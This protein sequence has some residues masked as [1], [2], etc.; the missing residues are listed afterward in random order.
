MHW[1]V[2]IGGA[3]G[4]LGKKSIK[5][6]LRSDQNGEVVW[7]TEEYESLEK[8]KQ[9]VLKLKEELE[10]ALQQGEMDWE[11]SG[12]TGMNQ[13]AVINSS[14]EEVWEQMQEF[15]DVLDMSNFFNQ[16]DEELRKK[17]AD[18]ILTQVSMFKGMAPYFAQNYDSVANKMV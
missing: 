10:S 9:E 13:G 2:S 5:L 17:T 16:L 6:G 12:K 7:V 8:W 18:Y 15:E 3:Q 1:T 11:N 14:P 4:E